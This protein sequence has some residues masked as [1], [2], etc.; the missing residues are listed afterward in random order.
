[1]SHDSG[2]RG[3]PIQDTGASTMTVS[4]GWSAAGGAFCPGCVTD[5]KGSTNHLPCREPVRLGVVE[6]LVA[7]R[8]LARRL[9]PYFSGVL[10]RHGPDFAIAT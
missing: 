10:I 6:D 4:G 5:H 1:M 8:A 3:R 7:D 2:V 9:P